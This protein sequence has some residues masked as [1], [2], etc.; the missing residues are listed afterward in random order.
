MN[1]NS[2]PIKSILSF[3]KPYKKWLFICVFFSLLSVIV[4]ITLPVIFK[5]FIDLVAVGKSTEEFPKYMTIIII[6]LF[7]GTGNLF[8]RRLSTARF[9][10]YSMKNLR[11]SIATHVQKLQFKHIRKYHS[12]DLAS[13]V[14]D[15]I[16]LIRKFLINLSDY[17]YQPLIFIAAVTLGVILSW[18]LLLATMA[19]L[20]IAIGLN[21]IAS[22]PLDKFSGKLQNRFGKLNSLIQD[23]VKG[24]HI[25]KSF[26]LKEK[27]QSNYQSKQDDAYKMEIKIAKRRLYVMT[28]RTLLLIV[29][30]QVMN[31]YGGRL[32][33]IGEMTEGDFA[34]FLA[35]INYLTA[36]V[37]TLI[38]LISNLK[39]AK[40]GA[41]RIDEI[42]SYPIE[43][44]FEK[45][46][47]FSRKNDTS[48]ELTNVFFSYDEE[49]YVLNDIKFKLHRNKT[50]ALVG[51][52]GGGKSTILN[53]LC[54]FY[55]VK[56]GEIKIFGNDVS[57]ID[58]EAL[59]S[60]ISMVTQDSH[61]YPTTVAENIGYGKKNSSRKEVI[62]A[63]KMAN[64]HDFIMKLPNGYDTILTEDGSN[65][66]GG[67]KQRISIARAILKDAPIL[68]L[69]EPTSALD[70]H[71]ERL[72]DDALYTFTKDKSVIVVAHRF[73]TIKNA[74]EIIVLDNGKIAQRGTHDEL[75]NSGGIYENLY[76]KQYEENGD[77]NLVKVVSHNV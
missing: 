56:N 24:I 19:I 18:K 8:F 30:I 15:D 65:L 17:M 40:G 45:K 68:L 48:V 53:L 64:A 37:N 77:D 2:K 39:V 16:D 13:R 59:R 52:S 54:G 50:I 20:V 47:V 3:G 27:L 42:L 55:R 36:P 7:F 6:L 34:A 58:K 74:D 10:A 31:L 33:F 29:P 11:N 75:M 25:V 14:N 70:S 22:K 43:E 71:S 21:K 1:K 63:A 51:V 9:A 35:I 49:N 41:Q 73:S 72:I 4:N 60:Q 28:I 46:S 44:N 23:T 69:D 26:N 66:S 76:L 5:R 38:E 57:K 12:G 67:Q 32:T 61:I 62:N